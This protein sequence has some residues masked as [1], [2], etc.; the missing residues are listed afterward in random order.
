MTSVK[1]VSSDGKD[2][3]AEC[4]AAFD[5]FNGLDKNFTYHRYPDTRSASR[6]KVVHA[7]A[8]QPSDFIVAYQRYVELGISGLGGA[9]PKLSVW[10]VETKATTH[11]RLK[12]DSLR[13]Y[14]ML[15]KFWWAGVEPIVP[16]HLIAED[17][18]VALMAYRLFPGQNPFVYNDDKTPAS[19]DFEGLFRYKDA[20]TLLRDVF[21]FKKV[22]Q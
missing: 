22:K 4:R 3:E 13:Q 9:Y 20:E 2:E 17:A 1:L 16:V 8:A 21:S 7:L 10:H 12:L 14:G 5:L 6:G 19:F 15:K 11:K 18:W